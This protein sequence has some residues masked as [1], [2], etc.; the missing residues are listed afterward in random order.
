MMISVAVTKQR[1]V[2]IRCMGTGHQH[3]GEWLYNSQTNKHEL[4]AH[5]TCPL[6]RGKGIV[7]IVPIPD[8][9]E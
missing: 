6:C 1:S 8:E 3:D 4:T 7:Y 2:C 5:S 9:D